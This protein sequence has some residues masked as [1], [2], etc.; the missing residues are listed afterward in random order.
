[1]LSIR[2]SAYIVVL[3]VLFASF[4]SGCGSL[5]NDETGEKIM[6]LTD[7]LKSDLS[8]V[9]G[10]DLQFSDGNKLSI[11]DSKTIQDI[12]SQIK[13]IKVQET[14]SKGVGY[15]YYLDLNEG[16]KTYRLNS[17]LTFGEKTYEATDNN[18]NKLNE[19]ILKLGRGK[20]PGLLS[21]VK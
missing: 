9:D 16:N 21:G 11:T 5:E 3:L 4:L 2:K 20:I 6:P 10:I 15:L 7:V 1:M 17:N 19:F 13:N 14:I 8:K 18:A 12:V